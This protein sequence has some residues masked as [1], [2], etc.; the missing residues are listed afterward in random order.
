[1][2]VTFCKKPCNLNLLF[3]LATN[4][5][6]HFIKVFCKI[7]Y[8]RKIIGVTAVTS[9][10]QQQPLPDYCAKHETQFGFLFFILAFCNVLK[11]NKLN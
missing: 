9:S 11:L 5:K 2:P 6:V 8:I 10:Q 7:A 4:N 1:M 3:T